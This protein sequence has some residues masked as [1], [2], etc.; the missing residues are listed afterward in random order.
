MKNESMDVTD[1]EQAG[2]HHS[3]KNEFQERWKHTEKILKT[4]RRSN[5][6][7]IY[8]NIYY[9]SKTKGY[10]DCLLK[11]NYIPDED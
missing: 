10:Q 8:T 3:Q 2:A 5:I 7:Y 9:K 4:D 1:S 6:Y 11:E